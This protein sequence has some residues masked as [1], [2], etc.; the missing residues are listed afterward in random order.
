[1]FFISRHR[2]QPGSSVLSQR[3][4]KDVRQRGKTKLDTSFKVEKHNKKDAKWRKM[5]ANLYNALFTNNKIM[6]W[7]TFVSTRGPLF[8]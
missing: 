4:Q 8:G 5:I 7:L 6:F 2:K 3:R 1:M